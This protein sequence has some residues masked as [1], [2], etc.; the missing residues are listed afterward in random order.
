MKGNFQYQIIVCLTSLWLLLPFSNFANSTYNT[1]TLRTLFRP[2]QSTPPPTCGT[3]SPD[4]A[5]L[6]ALYDATNGAKWTNAWDLTKSIDQWAGVTVDPTSCKVTKLDLSG[7]GLDGTI[8]EAFKGFTALTELR[9]NGNKLRGSVP[10]GVAISTLTLLYLHDNQFTGKLPTEFAAIK[11]LKQLNLSKNKFTDVPTFAVSNSFTELNVDNNQLG[12]G[13]LEDNVKIP[14]I[15]Y[16]PQDSLAT[17]TTIIVKEGD[18]VD[19]ATAVSGTLNSYQWYRQ[20]GAN[21]VIFNN[22]TNALTFPDVRTADAGNYQLRI[23]NSA[24]QGLTLVRRFVRLRVTPCSVTRTTIE[25]SQDYCEGDVLP[26]LTGTEAQSGITSLKVSYQWQRSIDS[27]NWIDIG[28][29]KDYKITG[30]ATTTWYRR[31]AIDGRCKNDT[32]NVVKVTFLRRISGN[33]ITT[34]STLL[35]DKSKPDSLV[36]S[37]PQGSGGIYKYLWQSSRNRQA[38]TDEDRAK[39]FFPIIASDTMYFRRIVSGICGKPDTSSVITIRVVKT[40]PKNEV[41]SN[42]FACPNGKGLAL[43]DTIK[44]FKVDSVSFK[45]LWEIS[46]D[47]QK[48]ARADTTKS[49]TDTL[50]YF[51][52]NGQT[53]DSYYRRWI[54]NGCDSILSNIVKVT[55]H[56]RILR[57]TISTDSEVFCQAD[58]VGINLTGT[59][60]VGGGE[61]Y[62]YIWQ[63][64]SDKKLWNNRGDSLNLP[65]PALT[66]TTYFRRIVNSLCYTDTSNV[67]KINYIFQFGRNEIGPSTRNCVGDSTAVLTGTKPAVKGY[68]EYQWIFSR[69]S[70]N[71]VGI[72]TLG[73]GLDYKVGRLPEGKYYFRRLVFNGCTVDSSNR[74]LIEMVSPIQNNTISGAGQFCEGDSLPTLVGSVPTGGGTKNY[75]YTWQS[76]NDNRNWAIAGREKDFKPQSII[77]STLYRRLVLGDA[78]NPDTSNVIT[79]KFANRLSNNRITDNQNICI[80]DIVKDSLRGTIPFGGDSTYVYI[81]QSTQDSVWRSVG[82]GRNHLPK[83]VLKT[84]QYRRIVLSGCFRDT[85]NVVRVAVVQPI[86]NNFILSGSQIRCRGIKPDSIRGSLPNDGGTNIFKYQWQQSTNQRQW[87]NINNAT[88]KDLVLSTTPDITTF[89]RRVVSSLCFSDT[90][91]SERILVLQSPNIRAGRDTIVNIGYEIRLNAGGGVSYLWSPKES[92]VDNDTTSASPLVRPSQTTQYIVVGKDATGCIGADTVLVIVIDNPLTKTVDIITPNGDGLNDNLYI[93]N[94]E[95]YPDNLLIVFNRWGGEVYRKKNYKN[96]WNGT[97]DGVSLPTGVYFYVLSFENTKRVKTGA[98]HVLE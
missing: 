71:Y 34:K 21:L 96:D 32:S 86:L 78:C 44:D 74:V 61:Q 26:T 72:D 42:Q 45:Y 81:W 73:N 55:I 18:P 29:Q 10:V 22:T 92:I 36:G 51:T 54:R 89:Y 27:T 91:P 19:V 46:Y 13:S 50:Y 95:R 83:D 40:L 48:W 62:K 6:K 93:D 4:Y 58:T 84:T 47:R 31:L 43:R 98:I 38:W 20:S 15:K 24:V 64:S 28:T 66:D 37:T 25:K 14:I 68:F 88:A 85:S 80:G 65:K 82:S 53:K 97:I 76:S 94:I 52:P 63:S 57:N 16:I 41:G 12:F 77:R 33:T 60:P 90:T 17:D 56:P 11:T 87:T 49:Q 39:N 35:C 1:N 30:I 8:P 69:D 59:V 23:T 70:I 7:R 2:L 67:L 5:A 9:L 3:S 75:R 79:L